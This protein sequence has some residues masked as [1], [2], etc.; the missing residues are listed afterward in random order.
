MKRKL[1]IRSLGVLLATACG[2]FVSAQVT[3]PNSHLPIS[4]HV[5][6]GMEGHVNPQALAMKANALTAAARRGSLNISTQNFPPGSIYVG[7]SLPLWTFNVKGSR[8]GDHHLGVMVGR[9]PFRNAGTAS[10]PTFI[11]PLIFQTHTVAASFDPKTFKFATA[12]GETTVDPTAVDNKCLTAPNNVPLRVFQQSPLFKATPKPFN[13]NGTTVGATQYVDA[14][15]RA[16]F[17]S[18]LGRD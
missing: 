10:V 8:D 1:L 16:N 4:V 18:V 11:V 15:Q 14:F 6:R 2:A 5:P 3:N 7:N 17:W 12:P 13:F 9:D